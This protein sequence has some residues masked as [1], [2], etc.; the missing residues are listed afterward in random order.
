MGSDVRLVVRRSGHVRRDH[1][2]SVVPE[3][4]VE[5]RVK[6][7]LRLVRVAKEEVL[8]LTLAD[9]HPHRHVIDEELTI[10]FLLDGGRKAILGER[11]RGYCHSSSQEQAQYTPNRFRPASF[12]RLA[13]FR[14]F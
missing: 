8:A 10:P 2:V 1:L 6:V 14:S 4:E 5:V 3:S 13:N 12:R 7:V 9:V 11:G